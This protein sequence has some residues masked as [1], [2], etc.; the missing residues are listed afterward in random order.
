MR[1]QRPVLLSGNESIVL[2]LQGRHHL[3]DLRRGL[4]LLVDLGADTF[5]GIGQGAQRYLQR[6]QFGDLF[7]QCLSGRR[8]VGLGQVV[9]H[10][11]GEADD[12]MAVLGHPVL[13]Q[14]GHAARHL[15]LADP[16]G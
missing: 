15:H 6:S 1:Q 8:E 16:R 3:S 2:A 7:Q 4:D 5:A 14:V 10:V 13:Q 9:R 12:F 11:N